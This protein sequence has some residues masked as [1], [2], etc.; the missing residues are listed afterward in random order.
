MKLLRVKDRPLHYAGKDLS[1][2]TQVRVP[3]NIARMLIATGRAEEVRYPPP[4][5]PA[6]PPRRSYRRRDMVAEQ[7]AEVVATEPPKESAED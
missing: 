6:P 4:L 2:G 1:V 7:P 5:S 3:G